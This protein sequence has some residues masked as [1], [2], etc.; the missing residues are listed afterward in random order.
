MAGNFR[1]SRHGDRVATLVPPPVADSTAAPLEPPLH[2]T[3]EQR[4]IWRAKLAALPPGFI[5]REQSDIFE[6][7]CVCRDQWLQA[8]AIVAKDGLLAAGRD[9]TDVRHPA[10]VVQTRMADQ[11][12]RLEATLKLDDRDAIRQAQP[13]PV[14]PWFRPKEPA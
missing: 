6:M 7:W 1:P 12:R 10:T 8:S 11:L 5:R 3:A 13:Q 14:P 4:D 2:L 9:G